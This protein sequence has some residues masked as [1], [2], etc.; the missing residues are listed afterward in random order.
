MTALPEPLTPAESDLR[1]FAFMPLDVLRLRDSDIA[2]LSTGDEFRCAVLLWCASWHQ[3]PAGSLP[4]DDKVLSQ[5]AGF[6]RVVKEWQKSREGALRNWIKCADGRLYHPV[7]AEQVKWRRGHPQQ[8]GRDGAGTK[9][10]D[11]DHFQ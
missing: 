3:V 7:V 5:L 9:R 4:D 8:V 2:A 1:E 11:A 6:G 10:I